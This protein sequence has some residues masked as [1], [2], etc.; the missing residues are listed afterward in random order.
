MSAS[1]DQPKPGPSESTRSDSTPTRGTTPSHRLSQLTVM[2]G[3]FVTFGGLYGY[4]L[5]VPTQPTMLASIVPWLAVGFLT[6]W[7]G[8]ILGGNSMVALPPQVRPALRGQSVVAGIGTVAGALSAA[9]VVLR[10]G[11]WTVS[12]PGVPSELTLAAVAGAI[13]WVGGLLIGRSMRRFVLSK[14]RRAQ[15]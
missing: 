4:A 14:R 8:G 13:V 3:L 5:Q 1:D 2:V 11:P 15:R 12:D 9:V 10:I 7:I 6:T